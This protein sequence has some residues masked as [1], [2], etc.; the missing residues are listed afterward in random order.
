MFKSVKKLIAWSGLFSKRLTI[1]YIFS[2]L[3]AIFT[4][5]PIMLSAYAMNLVI[6][7]WNGEKVLEPSQILM[8]FIA[9]IILVLLRA[10]FAYLRATFQDSIAYEQTADER[11]RIGEILKRVSLGFFSQ[12]S[13]GEITTAVTTDLSYFEMFAMKMLDTVVTGYITAGVMVVGLM[14]FNPLAGMVSV[15]G[16]LLSMLALKILFKKSTE[17]APTHQKAQDEMTSAVL[18]Y[19]HGISL[20]KAFKCTGVA[21]KGVSNAFKKHCEINIKIEKEYAVYNAMHLLVLKVASAGVVFVSAVMAFNNLISIPVLLMMLFYSFVI[22]SNVEGINAAL[23][24]FSILDEVMD[25]L[26]KI[27]KAKFLDEKSIDIKLSSYNIEFN[28]VSFFYDKRKVIDNVSFKIPEKTVTAIVG[29]S[30]GGKTTL[31]KLMARFYDVN[32]GVITVGGKNVKDFT[33]DS[34]LQNYSMVFQNVYLF[35]DTIENNICFGKPNATFDEIKNAAQ[36]ACCHDFIM[37]LPNK[38]KTIVGEGGCTLSGGEKQ[39]ISIARAILKDAPIVI[40]DEATASVDPEN[41]HAIQQAISNLVEDKTLVIIAHRLATVQ[42][43]DQI[44]VIE[45]GKVKEK[46]KHDELIKLNGVYNKFWEIRKSAENW[47]V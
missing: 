35:K 15:V 46:G 31:T 29:P 25:K 40:L 37:Q 34:L 17:N 47:Q 2:F 8:V 16:I 28:N 19:V 36:K 39:R 26:I 22:F 7:D 21:S 1:G 42:S 24:V 45:N 10:F 32:E 18:E 41:E 11:I 30:G 43:A 6:M 14:F 13:T 5:L 12:K 4:S 44:L 38:Y 3:A 33:C 23:H 9:L 27:K 20:V